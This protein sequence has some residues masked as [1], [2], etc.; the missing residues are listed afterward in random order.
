MYGMICVSFE[1]L[2]NFAELWFG[3]LYGDPNYKDG[4]PMSAKEAV[5]IVRSRVRMDMPPFSK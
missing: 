5:D 2:V 3:S 1:I 4:Y